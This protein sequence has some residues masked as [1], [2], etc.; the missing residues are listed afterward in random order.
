MHEA[1][2]PLKKC[3]IQTKAGPVKD[4]SSNKAQPFFQDD[5]DCCL[6]LHTYPNAKALNIYLHLSAGE[7]LRQF[8]RI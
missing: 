3:S 7:I 5:G 1:F 2:K 4:A 8:S 6:L